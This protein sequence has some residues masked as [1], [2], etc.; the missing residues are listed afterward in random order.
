MRRMPRRP[1]PAPVVDFIT[2][3]EAGVV[4]AAVHAAVAKVVQNEV[5]KGALAQSRATDII[6]ALTDEIGALFKLWK[7]DSKGSQ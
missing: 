3:L 1:Q 4:E 7:V 6:A 2:D 5:S